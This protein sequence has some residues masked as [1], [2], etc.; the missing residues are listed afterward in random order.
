VGKAAAEFCHPAGSVKFIIIVNNVLGAKTSLRG[1][2]S[3]PALS[4]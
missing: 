4:I 1:A 3:S 2:N